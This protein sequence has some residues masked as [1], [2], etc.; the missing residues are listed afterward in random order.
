[1]KK[2]LK[3]KEIVQYAGSEKVHMSLSVNSQIEE[4]LLMQ[5]LTELYDNPIEASV[6][7]VVSNSIDATSSLGNLGRIEIFKPSRLNPVF[8]RKG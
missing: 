1:M 6:R 3:K 2:T 8:Y 4:G 7:E 5:R